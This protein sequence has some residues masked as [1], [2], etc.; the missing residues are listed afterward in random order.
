MFSIHLDRDIWLHSP[1]YR[2]ISALG[3]FVVGYCAIFRL[4]VLVPTQQ[5]QMPNLNV[6]YVSSCAEVLIY[7]ENRVFYCTHITINPRLTF[8]FLTEFRNCKCVPISWTS[9]CS[10]MKTMHLMIREPSY[11]GPPIYGTINRNSAQ[12]R[13]RHFCQGGFDY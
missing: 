7:Y 12:Y 9:F 1:L 5:G 3:F 6:I 4:P 8:A 11:H 2:Y 13:V 10:E